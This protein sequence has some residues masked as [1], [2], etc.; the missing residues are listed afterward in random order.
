MEE[1]ARH[2]SKDDL[3]V[4]L[5]G[6]VYDLTT[7]YKSHPGGAKLIL[8]VAGMDATAQFEPFHPSDI[9]K[10]LLGDSVTVGRVD[11]KTVKEEN[12]AA[13][14]ER[15]AGGNGTGDGDQVANIFRERIVARGFGSG[16]WG[17]GTA[18]SIKS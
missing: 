4:V 3:W 17:W 9:V 5:N 13:P 18:Y 11:E 10:R 15:D 7:F 16:A 1:V 14:L 8:D 6:M 12:I 2:K